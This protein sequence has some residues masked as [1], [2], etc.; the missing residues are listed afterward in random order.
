M[1]HVFTLSAPFLGA[2]AL[3]RPAGAP[4]VRLMQPAAPAWWTQPCACSPNLDPVIGKDGVVYKNTCTAACHGVEVQ[5]PAGGFSGA[6]GGI[7][8][9]NSETVRVIGLSAIG[10]ALGYAAAY[11]LFFRR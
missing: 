8:D 5:G 6:F 3:G 10:L 2:A 4:N 9:A 11:V 7:G 1:P